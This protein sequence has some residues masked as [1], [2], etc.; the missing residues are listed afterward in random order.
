MTVVSYDVVRERVARGA[1]LL[2]EKSPGW[3][4]TLVP[5]SVVMHYYDSCV[6]GLLNPEVGYAGM[7]DA[8]GLK[9]DTETDAEG[10]LVWHGFDL[11]DDECAVNP[12]YRESYAR[13]T[14]TWRNL[15]A[16]RQIAAGLR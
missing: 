14:D 15:I 11:I 8:L 12:D 4:R 6:L 1:A 13:L 7:V 16:E 10:G 2:D 3:F 5:E 9:H